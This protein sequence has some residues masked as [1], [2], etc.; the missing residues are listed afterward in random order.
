MD[1]KICEEVLFLLVCSDLIKR[2]VYKYN[3]QTIFKG[4]L[5]IG[6][7]KNAKYW[8]YGTRLVKELSYRVR[9]G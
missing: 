3:C 2:R 9:F 4:K 8:K 5:W 7:L 1:I 6:M